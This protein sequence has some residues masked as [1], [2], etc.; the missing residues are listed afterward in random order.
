[1]VVPRQRVIEVLTLASDKVNRENKSRAELA[2]GAYLR[3][4]Y[5]KYGVL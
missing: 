2:N 4:V 5:N 3:D 1:V